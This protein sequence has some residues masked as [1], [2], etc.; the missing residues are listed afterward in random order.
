MATRFVPQL[1]MVARPGAPCHA[2][3][4]IQRP[5]VQRAWSPFRRGEYWSV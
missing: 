1:M 3:I 4:A 2:T 5:P